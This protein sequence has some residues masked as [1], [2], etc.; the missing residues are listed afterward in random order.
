T[1]VEAA[2]PRLLVPDPGAGLLGEGGWH[3]TG[4]RLVTRSLELLRAFSDRCAEEGV[5]FRLQATGSTTLVPEELVPHAR[6]LAALQRGAGADVREV[7]LEDVPG[8]PLHAGIDLDG[9]AAA[10]HYPRDAWGLPRLYAEVLASALPVVRG[11]ARLVVREGRASVQV[12]GEPLAA[13]AVV[14]ACGV[15]TRALLR[16]AGL[17]APLQAYRT[18]AVRLVHPRAAAVPILHDA[19]Q[20]CYLRPHAPGQMLVGD[21]TTTTPED[22]LRWKADAD[23]AFVEASLARVRRRFPF[24]ADARPGDAWAGVDAATPD[25]LLL[26]GPHPDQP[27]VWL[28]AGGNGHGFMRA[29]AVGESLAATMLGQ[30]PRVPLDAY[31]PGRFAGRMGMDFRIREGYALEGPGLSETAEVGPRGG[32]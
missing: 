30:R 16:G 13:D 10:F 19:A 8:L 1:L 15:H 9:V 28:L 26:A 31:D 32:R 18:Q 11:A 22:P 5:P 3:P 29:P 20:G 24:L 27:D 6:A 25:R 12:D 14:V 21:G 23:A 17:D 2:A 7:P 4:V